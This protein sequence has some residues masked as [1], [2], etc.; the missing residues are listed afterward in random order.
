V[1][2][3]KSFWVLSSCINCS[4]FIVRSEINLSLSL[5]FRRDRNAPCVNSASNFCYIYGEIT[6]PFTFNLSDMVSLLQYCNMGDQDE[7]CVLHVCCTTWSSKLN[8]LV[9]RKGCSVPFAV[10]IV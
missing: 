10:P 6:N 1:E 4:V 9:N 3:Y 2:L 7:S 5:C 8:A